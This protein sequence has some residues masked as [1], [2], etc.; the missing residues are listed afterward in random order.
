MDNEMDEN[1]MNVETLEGDAIIPVA[2][3]KPP[4]G[5]G[6]PI[7]LAE[8]AI[9]LEIKATLFSHPESDFTLFRLID[10][11]GRVI[12]EKKIEGY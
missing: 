6:F 1:L 11:N 12:G 9:Y 3:R 5:P 10:E 8:R 4:F 2:T 7:E